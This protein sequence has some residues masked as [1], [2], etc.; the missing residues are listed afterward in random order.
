VFTLKV[1][2]KQYFYKS[3]MALAV[4]LLILLTFAMPVFAK[5]AIPDENQNLKTSASWSDGDTLILHIIDMDTM[6]LQ[7]VAI[8]LSDFVSD[9]ENVPYILLQAQDFFGERQSGVIQV[10]NPLFVPPGI[11]VGQTVGDSGSSLDISELPDDLQNI[12]TD[13]N[14]PHHAPPALTPD[15]T[16]TVVDNIM[17][18]NE[19]EFFTVTTENGSDFFLIIDRQRP[20][21][22]VYLLNTV[23]ESDLMALADARGETLPPSSSSVTPTEPLEQPPT[24]TMEEILQAIQETTEQNPHNQAPAAPV[25]QG[26]SSGLL[27]FA[28]IALFAGAVFLAWKYLWPKIR[29]FLQKKHEPVDDEDNYYEHDDGDDDNHDEFGAV[30]PDEDDD[31]YEDDEPD[32][33]NEGGEEYAE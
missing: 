15:G 31:Y 12:V 6:E 10:E 3:A 28:G 29:D 18:V 33:E 30:V 23:T 25:S 11:Q 32:Q 2:T 20:N 17:T 13:A 8:R 19:I 22:N 5:E 14:Q 26:T 21:N 16:G 24:L 4:A 9:N 1:L 27:L 7:Q